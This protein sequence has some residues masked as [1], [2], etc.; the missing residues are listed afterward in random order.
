M[1][2]LIL[3]LVA[4][5]CYLGVSRLPVPDWAKAVLLFTSQIALY[6]FV[7]AITKHHLQ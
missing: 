5:G 3:I 2:A 7:S 6:I 1:R 4:V